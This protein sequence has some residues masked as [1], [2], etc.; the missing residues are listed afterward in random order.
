MYKKVGDGHLLRLWKC[1]VEIDAK[2]LD[3]LRHIVKERYLW[4]ITLLR[5][6]V[7]EQL[8]EKSQIFQ[9]VCGGLSITDYCVLR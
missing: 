6:R 9:Y 5:S 2:P 1:T 7:L 3:I 8:D 4:D